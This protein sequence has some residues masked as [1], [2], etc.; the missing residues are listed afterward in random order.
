MLSAVDDST[1]NAILCIIIIIIIIIV[2]II[3]YFSY[4]PTTSILCL[5]CAVFRLCQNC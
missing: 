3:I 2:I 1:M 5:F 4:N